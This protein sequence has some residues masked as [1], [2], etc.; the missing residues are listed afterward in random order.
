MSSRHR[1]AR[2]MILLLA[3]SCVIL[4][5]QDAPPAKPPV[6]Q[7]LPP[8]NDPKEIIRRAL[9]A[10]QADFQLARNYTFERREEIKVMNKQGGLKKHEINTYDI[11]F[12]YGQ[13]WSRH[14]GED[15]KPLSDRETKKE[16]DKLDKLIAERENESQKEREK[17][18]AEQ[19]KERQEGRAFV[20]DIINAYD[21]R[22]VGDDHVDGIDAYVLDAVPRADFRPTRPHA[23]V[24]S[25]LRGQLWISKSDYGCVRLRAETLDTISWGFFLLRVHKG[26][27]FQ[28]DQTR[29]ND[30]VWLP[31][32][33]SINGSARLAVF[34]NDV[35]D[36]ESTFFDYKRFSS[37]VRILPGAR[38]IQP[39][40]DSTQ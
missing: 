15:D 22:L 24:L 5:A 36:W 8:T 39:G 27:Q 4:R 12:L 33:I 20:Q 9:E 18:L 37:G 13:P 21:F 6:R 34:V 40:R 19:E 1:K 7:E 11:M 32:T 38:E 23:D 16:S 14:I 31:H 29:V 28:L 17:R 3:V 30:E 10:D 26:A 2:L 35:V 25:K